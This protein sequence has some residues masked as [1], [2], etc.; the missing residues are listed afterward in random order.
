MS[1]ENSSLAGFPQ[2]SSLQLA[3]R[4][5]GH[6]RNVLHGRQAVSF[7]PGRVHG[8]VGPQL[9]GFKH[10]RRMLTRPHRRPAEFL[11]GI[12]AAGVIDVRMAYPNE[13][14]V[15]RVETELADIF[16]HPGGRLGQPGIEQYEFVARVD[17]DRGESG[18]PDEPRVA[19][20]MNGSC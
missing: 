15:L 18:N 3:R 19:E 10:L 9:A 8:I 13:G 17:K 16:G 6:D 7:R 2:Q 20:D 12:D 1:G 11:Q 4:A 5:V 14:D